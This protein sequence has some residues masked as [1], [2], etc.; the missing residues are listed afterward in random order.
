MCNSKFEPA[1]YNFNSEISFVVQWAYPSSVS[2]RCPRYTDALRDIAISSTFLFLA[3][4]VRWPS[5]EAPR[6][7]T[8][9]LYRPY[10]LGY[11]RPLWD[12]SH[13]RHHR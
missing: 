10:I 1:L 4:L 6:S 12:R 13:A 8:Q 11:I 7:K 9:A 3:V 5:M 2:N